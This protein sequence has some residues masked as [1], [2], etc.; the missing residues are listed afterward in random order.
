MGA[1][2]EGVASPCPLAKPPEA[3][4]SRWPVETPY[5]SP[6][7]HSEKPKEPSRQGAESENHWR[8]RPVDRLWF[9]GPRHLSMAAGQGKAGEVAD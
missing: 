8:L 6:S 7:K 9:D 1:S 5:F 4:K 2:V 3:P